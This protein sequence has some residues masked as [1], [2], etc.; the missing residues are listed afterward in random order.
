VDKLDIRLLD[1]DQTVA[2]G[3]HKAD[4]DTVHQLM[5]TIQGPARGRSQGPGGRSQ[6]PEDTGL[7]RAQGLESTGRD[8]VHC[9]E[10]T[11]KT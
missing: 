5:G 10:D 1:T 11:D 4:Q 9:L 3:A 6:A 7:G 2:V 8:M